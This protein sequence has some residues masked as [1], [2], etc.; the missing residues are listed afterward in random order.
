MFDKV[1]TVIVSR[2]AHSLTQKYRSTV[3]GS[4]PIL[5]LFQKDPTALEATLQQHLHHYMA[6]HRGTVP[7]RVFGFEEILPAEVLDF[8]F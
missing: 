5:H 3:M 2:A 7:L 1:T 4:P 6:P 8:R